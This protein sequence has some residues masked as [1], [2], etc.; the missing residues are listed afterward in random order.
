MLLHTSVNPDINEV[1]GAGVRHSVVSANAISAGKLFRPFL[2][3][4]GADAL[5]WLPLISHGIVGLSLNTNLV[6][7]LMVYEVKEEADN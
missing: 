4:S 1:T 3:T 5:T 2:N 6:E 7:G